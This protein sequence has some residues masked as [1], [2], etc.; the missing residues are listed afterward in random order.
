M[1]RSVKRH[2]VF[3]SSI[4]AAL[5]LERASIERAIARDA[6]AVEP[7]VCHWPP[8]RSGVRPDRL[9]P[10]RPH[11]IVPQ[12]EIRAVPMA[13]TAR[14]ALRY[15]AERPLGPS[16]KWNARARGTSGGDDLRLAMLAAMPIEHALLI[17]GWGPHASGG[18]PSRVDFGRPPLV[19]DLYEP[20]SVIARVTIPALRELL[21][22]KRPGAR[23]RFGVDGFPFGYVAMQVACA[24]QRIYAEHERFGVWGYAFDELLLYWMTVDR[25]VLRICVGV[26]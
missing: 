12:V 22:P 5:R 2:A 11:W 23:S 19:V 17:R 6:D 15:C 3:P 10:Y 13:R 9:A 4:A 24:Y 26:D 18:D 8:S 14:G 7:N 16:A 20:L 25:G 21:L 1:T